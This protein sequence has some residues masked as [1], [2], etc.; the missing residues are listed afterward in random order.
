MVSVIVTEF[1]YGTE[2]V[3]AAVGTLVFP[4]FGLRTCTPPRFQA[5]HSCSPEGKALRPSCGSI[6][7]C[8]W[9]GVDHGSTKKEKCCQLCPYMYIHFFQRNQTG[10]VTKNQVQVETVVEKNVVFSISTEITTPRF[11]FFFSRFDLCGSVASS[12]LF[13]VLP[14]VDCVLYAGYNDAPSLRP[15]RDKL[16]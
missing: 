5:N 13:C 11:F 7:S 12:C 16:M 6:N 9:G 15:P 14:W 4:P 2:E 1:T 10:K 8:S 3:R